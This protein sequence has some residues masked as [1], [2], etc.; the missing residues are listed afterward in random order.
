M[1]LI[2]SLIFPDL[3]FVA[4]VMSSMHAICNAHSSLFDLAILTVL[5][6]DPDYTIFSISS[7]V[8]Y[9][10]IPMVRGFRLCLCGTAVF[11]AH[12]TNEYEALVERCLTKNQ[13]SRREP[14]SIAAWSTRNLTLGLLVLGLDPS[15]FPYHPLSHD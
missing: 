14:C 9:F 8:L 5:G 10:I 13:S 6:E 7:F 3:T 1:S 2:P 12:M 4:F 11:T 15:I